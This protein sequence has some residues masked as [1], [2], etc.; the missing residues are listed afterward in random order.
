MVV[1]GFT[2]LN[3]NTVGLQLNISH[4]TPGSIWSE[5]ITHSQ[6]NAEEVQ[7]CL[8]RILH[9]IAQAQVSEDGVIPKGVSGCAYRAASRHAI[10]KIKVLTTAILSPSSAFN[11][12]TDIAAKPLVANASKAFSRMVSSLSSGGR[13]RFV[14]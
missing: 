3:R 7:S 10:L 12:R 9:S 14:T 6:G 4:P 1:Q 8:T 11:A 5:A 13:P 2:A